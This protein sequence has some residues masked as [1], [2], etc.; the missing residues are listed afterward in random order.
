MEEVGFGLTGIA[1]NGGSQ[2]WPNWKGLEWRK[3]VLASL[4]WL[5]MEEVGFG[6]TGIAWNRISQ[7]W[8]AWMAWNKINWFWTDKNGLEWFYICSSPEEASML[9]NIQE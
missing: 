7:S 6:L 3:S 2:F 4:E 9:A 1:W 8:L 5:V